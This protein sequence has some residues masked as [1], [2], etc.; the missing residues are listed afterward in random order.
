[1]TSVTDAFEDI[2][3]RA[4]RMSGERDVRGRAAEETPAAALEL[5]SRTS[6]DGAPNGLDRL[7]VASSKPGR[8]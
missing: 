8:S 6:S 1:M 3:V 5:T 4:G 7:R 2:E